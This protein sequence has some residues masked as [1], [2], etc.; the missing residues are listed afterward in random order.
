M[1]LGLRI[2]STPL[3]MDSRAPSL[4]STVPAPM[5]TR[6]LKRLDSLLMELKDPE[7]SIVT[8]SAITHLQLDF[9]RL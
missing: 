8:S 1:K 2:N 9:L 4:S 3:S 7:M 5:M 6:S